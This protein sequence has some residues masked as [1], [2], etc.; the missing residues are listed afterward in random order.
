MGFQKGVSGN[1]GG[2]SKTPKEVQTLARQYTAQAIGALVKA[3]AEPN[4]RVKAADILLERGWGK[5]TQPY[6]GPDGGALE[7][8]HRIERAIVRPP[9]RDG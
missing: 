5:V 3:L 1:P 9:H 7:V 4:E 8:I 6:S 2:K